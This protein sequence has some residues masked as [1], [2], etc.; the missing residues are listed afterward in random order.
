MDNISYNTKVVV[1]YPFYDPELRVFTIDKI[2]IEDVIGFEEMTEIIYQSELLKVFNLNP[3][4]DVNISCQEIDKIFAH[5]QQVNNESIK[6][7]I[8]CVENVKEKCFCSTLEEAFMFMFSYTY[9]FL[10][11]KCICNILENGEI[12]HE[13]L[14]QLQ[15]ILQIVE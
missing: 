2:D 3:G 1:T 10:T 8:K 15:T 11:H 5:I 9:F 4:Q 6:E 7:F 12:Q 13:N 14:N